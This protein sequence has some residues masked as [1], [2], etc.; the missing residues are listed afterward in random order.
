[1]NL[2]N[3]I[4]L[5]RM[6]MIPC[7][8]LAVLYYA[9]GV[10]IGAP[11]EWQ[12]WLAMTFFALATLSDGVDGYIAR[13]LNEKTRL[14]SILDPIADKALLLT[15]LFLLSWNHGRAFDQIPLWF[16]VIVI[17][18]DIVVVLGVALIFMMGRGFDV[19][20]S[21]T[22]KI[23]TALQMIT[24]GIVLLKLPGLYWEI[25]LWAAA[26]CTVVSGAAYVVHG[27]R[28]LTVNP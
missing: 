20:P 27:M 28:K 25:P 9:K 17:S 1:M 12:R 18:R 3:T 19:Q 10:A 8:V 26:V 11:Q 22:G 2:A 13:H 6:A 5:S 16:P 21:W 7:F 14:G 15:S 23:A 24:L 4:T